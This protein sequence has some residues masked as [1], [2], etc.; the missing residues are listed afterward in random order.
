MIFPLDYMFT[1]CQW[2]QKKKI[3]V[4]RLPVRR[5]PPDAKIRNMIQRSLRSVVPDIE[6]IIP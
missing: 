3:R 6:R 4:N 1:L 5:R 2:N